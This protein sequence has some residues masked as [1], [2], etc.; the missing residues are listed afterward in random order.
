MRKPD[1]TPEERETAKQEYIAFQNGPVWAN[2]RQETIRESI[3][4]L[5]EKLG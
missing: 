1:Q 5:R 4:M 2:W 3:A